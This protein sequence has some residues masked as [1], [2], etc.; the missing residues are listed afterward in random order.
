MKSLIP[1]KNRERSAAPALWGDSWFDRVWEDPFR[2]ALSPFEGNHLPKMPSVDVEENGREVS[3]RAE[4]PGMN[5]KDIDLTWQYGVLRIRGEKKSEKEE[6]RKGGYYRES[7]YGS[8]N[9]EIP[10]GDSVDWKNAKA[11]YR[12]GVLTVK[13]PKTEGAKKAITVKVN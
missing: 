11:N 6:K 13:L 9:R 3:V 8:F 12:N 1:W 5:E 2:F 10:L 4:V 7:T